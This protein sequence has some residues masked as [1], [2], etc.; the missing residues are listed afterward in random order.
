MD[1]LVSRGP[2][3]LSGALSGS[4]SVCECMYVYM[5]SMCVCV[6]ACMCVYVCVCVCVYDAL[7]ESISKGQ[8]AAM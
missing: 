8:Q 1:D 6:R 7:P 3:N 2:M 5:Y 4:P